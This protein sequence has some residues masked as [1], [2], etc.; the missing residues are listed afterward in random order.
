MPSCRAFVHVCMPR[1]AAPRRAFRTETRAA[2]ARRTARQAPKA[3]PTA[4]SALWAQART[5]ARL[6]LPHAAV[7]RR[8]RAACRRHGGA[9]LCDQHTR[10]RTA[11]T[12][13]GKRGHAWLR[14]TAD[15]RIHARTYKRAVLQR[16]RNNGTVPRRSMPQYSCSMCACAGSDRTSSSNATGYSPSSSRSTEDSWYS[17]FSSARPSAAPCTAAAHAASNSSRQLRRTLSA[18][19]AT[20][21]WPSA[22][23]VGDRRRRR[24]TLSAGGDGFCGLSAAAAAP[25]S[26]ASYPADRRRPITIY[27]RQRIFDRCNRYWQ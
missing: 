6:R 5:C 7:R 17:T 23:C 25:N 22:C 11:L 10:T 21:A 8:G 20:P 16:C 3:I 19:P 27:G 15:A 13:K 4:T 18:T 1:R 14:G 12:R 24:I 26:V 9:R 2:S